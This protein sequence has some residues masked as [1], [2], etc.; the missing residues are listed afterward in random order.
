M[1]DVFKRTGKGHN[2][3]ITSKCIFQINQYEYRTSK[4]IQNRFIHLVLCNYVIVTSDV[5]SNHY[6]KIS[7][8]TVCLKYT[9][10]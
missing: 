10:I 7:P 2:K 8:I 5:I 3:Q 4:N 6:D 1:L 9:Q